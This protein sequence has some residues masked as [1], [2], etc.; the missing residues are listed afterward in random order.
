MAKARK[1]LRREW[2]KA[3]VKQLKTMAKARVGVTKISK[4]LEPEG[5]CNAD[6]ADGLGLGVDH[7]RAATREN[8]RECAD[9]FCS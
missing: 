3:D 8:E 2:T 5:D 4:S 1:I 6:L 7:D 9:R